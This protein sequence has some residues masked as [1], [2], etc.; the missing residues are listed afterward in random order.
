MAV[1]I[2]IVDGSTSNRIILSAQVQA[3]GY[4]TRVCAGLDDAIEIARTEPVDALIISAGLLALPRFG[5][6][7]AILGSRGPAGIIATQV[8]DNGAGRMSALNAGAD[9]ALSA[10]LNAQLFAA[11]LRKLI[12][13][14]AAQRELLPEGG[15][16]DM[17]GFAEDTSGALTIPGNILLFSADDALAPSIKRL[18]R[19]RIQA[20][21]SAAPYKLPIV[22][23]PVDLVIIDQ[24]ARDLCDENALLALMA[25]M[26]A[27]DATRG[28]FQ[29]VLFPA[30]ADL[31]AAKA[32]DMGADDVIVGA[33]FSN[34]IAHRAGR[35]L[36]RKRQDAMM[37]TRLRDGLRA[38]AT[39]PL[40]GLAN[41]RCVLSRLVALSQG[42]LPVALLVIDLDHFKRVNDE[43]GHDVGDQVLVALADRLRS[44]AQSEELLARIGG[45]EFLLATPVADAQEAAAAATRLCALIRNAP[46]SAAQLSITASIGVAL[47][48]AP[49]FGEAEAQQ[50]IKRADEALYASKHAGRNRA[51]LAQS[52][53]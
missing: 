33:Q 53:A 41:R 36:R 10:S 38:A 24:R 27:R 48:E 16:P 46:L 42:R 25:E 32:L 44:G 7:R 14:C 47:C 13:Q 51:T 2:L 12:I 52:A 28:I 22:E 3:C 6:L 35:L 18:T 4:R 1:N 30:G 34:E 5:L 39:D 20:S 40:T 26:R 31:A 45:E 15:A 19:A 49:L 9:L 37:R 11:S 43:H 50:L 21:T 8:E 29:L 17:M 23:P